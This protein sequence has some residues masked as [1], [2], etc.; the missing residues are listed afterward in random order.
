[1]D[2]KTR[3]ALEELV[4]AAGRITCSRPHDAAEAVLQMRF[5]GA[6]ARAAALLDAPA[7]APL[8]GEVHAQPHVRPYRADPAGRWEVNAT[9]LSP[10][11]EDAERVAAALRAVLARLEA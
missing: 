1:M 3:E 5:E 2:A 9:V 10:S 11:R 7:E 8:R 6:R 4:E